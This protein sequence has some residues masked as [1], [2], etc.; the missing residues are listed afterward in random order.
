MGNLAQFDK[1]ISK[2]NEM[3]TVITLAKDN[4]EDISEDVN[5][6]SEKINETLNMR[7]L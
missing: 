6:L 5:K 2:L 7:C 4:G 1:E 3:E